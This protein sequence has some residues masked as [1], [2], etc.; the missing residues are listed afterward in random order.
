MNTNELFRGQKQTH[1]LRKQIDGCQDRGR[2]KLG[3]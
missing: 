2:G 3:V 1:S